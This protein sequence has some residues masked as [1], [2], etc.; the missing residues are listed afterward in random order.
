MVS[1]RERAPSTAVGIHAGMLY[2]GAVMQRARIS[3]DAEAAF[4]VL[5]ASPRKYSVLLK[6][7]STWNAL[8]LDVTATGSAQP[9][10][11]EKVATTLTDELARNFSMALSS[12][13]IARDTELNTVGYAATPAAVALGGGVQGQVAAVPSVA[14][15][16]ARPVRERYLAA[17]GF[18][19]P[20]FLWIGTTAQGQAFRTFLDA[21]GSGN[22]ST[23]PLWGNARSS[24]LDAPDCRVDRAGFPSLLG[25]PTSPGYATVGWLESDDAGTACNL[26]VD[27][28][29]FNTAGTHV[30]K[31]A[32][33]GDW[34]V[35][36]QQSGADRSGPTE[37]VGRQRDFATKAWSA[38][39]R[40]STQPV[41]RLLAQA[42][43]PGSAAW[44]AVTWQECA[45]MATDAACTTYA[46]KTQTAPGVL[47]TEL[48]LT[49]S[50]GR[51]L[52]TVNYYG[53]VVVAWVEPRAACKAD[54]SKQ[55]AQIRAR[56]L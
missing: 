36:E 28:T 22:Y 10:L 20:A 17:V 47:L 23:T 21:D 42:S 43:G 13:G 38:V 2:S 6:E 54:A 31:A 1:W 7:S 52:M 27:G 5:L 49:P 16:T 50:S 19:K 45:G 12:E 44:A 33:N 15:M 32:M 55:C 46:A 37:V 18:L 11:S 4:R 30:R 29:V 34:V 25:V 56:W 51:P 40:L 24:S 35:W 41:S 48:T 14:G 39:A 9:V 3:T 26:L 53:D 8:L